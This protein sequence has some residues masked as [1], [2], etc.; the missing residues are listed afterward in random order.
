MQGGKGC[1]GERKKG[2]SRFGQKKSKRLF[3]LEGGDAKRSV[4][5]GRAQRPRR[6]VDLDKFSQ[7]QAVP[8]MI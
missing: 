1:D 5:R 4:I 8:V 6:D 2:N 3:S 7:V